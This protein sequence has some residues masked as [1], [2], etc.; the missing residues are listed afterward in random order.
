MYKGK[1]IRNKITF[2]FYNLSSQRLFS[3]KYVPLND[4][5]LI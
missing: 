2:F 3:E 5:N 1:S 4:T